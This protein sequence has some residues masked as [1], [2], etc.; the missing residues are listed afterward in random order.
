MPCKLSKLFHSQTKGI[1]ETLRLFKKIQATYLQ[2]QKLYPLNIFDDLALG[3][4]IFIK[5]LKGNQGL[6][7]TWNRNLWSII[8]VSI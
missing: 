3:I 2:V 1:T 5:P 6:E 7:I 8:Y 4:S